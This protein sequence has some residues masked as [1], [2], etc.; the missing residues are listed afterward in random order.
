MV[1]GKPAEC[2]NTCTY[3]VPKSLHD[4]ARDFDGLGTLLNT[5]YGEPWDVCGGLET[6]SEAVAGA[7]DTVASALGGS[8][9]KA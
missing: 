1:S 6:L 2:G 8:A 5:S 9:Q 4:L 3:C 7:A